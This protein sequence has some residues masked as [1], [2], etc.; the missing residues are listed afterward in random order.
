M[1]RLLTLFLAL[2]I[3]SSMAFSADYNAVER[4]PVV[5]K[6]LL[7]KNGLPTDTTFKV[8]ESVADNSNTTTTNTAIKIYKALSNTPFLMLCALS[9][10]DIALKLPR[11]ALARS[12]APVVSLVSILSSPSHVFGCQSHQFLLA[13]RA[14]HALA[15]HSAAR[16]D[17]DAITH[18]DQLRHLT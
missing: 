1:K 3:T 14:A 16:N 8:V 9:L 7:E 10:P 18:A 4:V 5:G 6:V 17:Q 12:Q 2:G 13:V 11:L 15:C